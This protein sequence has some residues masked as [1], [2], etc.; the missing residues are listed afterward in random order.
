M[1]DQESSTSSIEEYRRLLSGCRL[2]PLRLLSAVVN[3]D[4]GRTSPL[5]AVLQPTESAS[6]VHPKGGS[7]PTVRCECG[8]IGKEGR[9]IVVRIAATF[10]ADLVSDEDLPDWFL[11]LYARANL[12][13][14][15]WPF[16]RQWVVSV[17]AMMG[18]QL[19]LP[20]RMMGMPP[21]AAEVTGPT[22]S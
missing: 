10:E 13:F 2:T 14:N 18:F 20:L 4:P 15:A 7:A 3:Q 21:P 5:P 1:S 19:W 11:E 8:V 12:P 6:F 9:R 17:A 16:W 22:H